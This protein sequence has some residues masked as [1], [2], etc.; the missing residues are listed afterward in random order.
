MVTSLPRPLLAPH[1]ALRGIAVT[2]QASFAHLHQFSVDAQN[3]S[4]M[5]SQPEF[6]AI[7]VTPLE[8]PLSTLKPSAGPASEE[9]CF[10]EEIDPASTLPPIIC[11]RTR[12]EVPDVD[13]PKPPQGEARL[14]GVAAPPS[15]RESRELWF[16]LAEASVRLSGSVLPPELEEVNRRFVDDEISAEEYLVLVLR[17]G[18]AFARMAGETPRPRPTPGGQVGD[19]MLRAV[20]EVCDG[21]VAHPQT[22]SGN[23]L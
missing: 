8:N 6:D 23:D 16:A 2:P 1:F 5:P 10:L 20:R 18:A 13:E 7:A 22:P 4:R 3:V 17:L 15:E 11:V 19:A 12:F 21:R 14:T 9:P